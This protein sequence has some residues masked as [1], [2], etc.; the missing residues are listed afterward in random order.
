MDP[1]VE[2]M[3]AQL[4]LW[5]RKISRLAD[6]AHNAGG[7]ARFEEIVRVDELKALHAIAQSKFDEF[8][9]AQGARRADLKDE[10]TSAWNELDLAL[11][12][13]H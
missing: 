5:A 10:L 9:R 4:M 11:K 3:G 6:K 7:T 1:T 8:G 13:P 2:K 12:A